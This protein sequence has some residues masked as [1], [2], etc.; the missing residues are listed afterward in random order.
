MAMELLAPVVGV[1]GLCFA[2]FLFLKVLSAPSGNDKMRS[3]SDSIHEGAMA[4]LNREYRAI[5]IFMVVMAVV[6]W[7]II[8]YQTAFAYVAGGFC[9]ILAGYFGMQAA[10]KANVRMAQAAVEKKQGRALSIAFS[11]GA[12]MGMSVASLGVLG[13]GI[14]YL[15]FPDPIM[16]AGVIAGFSMGASSIALF[17][18]VGGGIYT[19]SADV[20]ADLVG[21][22]EAGIPEDD[23]R[24][25]AVI[26]D[27]VGDNVG[28]VAGMGAD[29]FESY[30][31]SVVAT[32]AIGALMAAP[33]QMMLVPLML[34]AAGTL[35][36]IVG[37]FF[38]DILNNINPQSALRYATY[39]ASALFIASA[40]LLIRFIL[41]DISV[42]WAVLSGIV[43]GAA[44]GLITEFYTSGKS[45]E[46]LAESCKTGA[47]TNIIQGLALGMKS[48][49]WPMLMICAA[50]LIAFKFAG[51]YGVAISAVGM[52]GTIGIIMSVD[53]YGP[54]ADNGG[55]IVTMA[56]FG[57]EV[58]K[59]TDKLDSLGNTTAAIG[60]GFAIASAALTALGLFA[61]YAQVTLLAKIDIMNINVIAGILIG[62]LMPFMFAA[63]TM[64]A[65]GRAAFKMVEEVRRQFR[66]LGLLSGKGKPDIKKCVD[67]STSAALREMVVPGVSAVVVPLVVGLLL[68]PEALGGLLAG[69]LVCGVLMAIMMANAGAAWDNSKKFI[70]EGNLGGKGSDAH[71][72]AV[73]GDTVGDP[74]KD[75]SGPAMNILIKLMSIVSLVFGPAI[76]KFYP[77]ISGFLA[78]VF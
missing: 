50:T 54:I 70:E 7:Q 14:V 53:A 73:I 69:S 17:A 76:V 29:L 43:S 20:G 45:V 25:P 51:L 48:T 40:F 61:A 35:A 46:K 6:L 3:I 36:S 55:G 5:G 33:L 74:F 37:S 26:A 24:N 39:V 34:I 57:P 15:L 63:L 78:K 75:T 58:R 28:D 56:G 32:I 30:V 23:P 11:G 59:I 2:L 64:Q 67:I 12:V 42:F 4:F 60:K 41:G 18:R 9:S 8:N 52:L 21:K 22:I 1:V 68:G 16:K 71:K 66:D 27:N 47:A 65:V 62:G 44:I 10:T 31:G 38:V 13:L 77:V 19:K 49:M 72:A